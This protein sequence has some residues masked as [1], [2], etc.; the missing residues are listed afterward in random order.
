MTDRTRLEQL[1]TEELRRRAFSTAEHRLDVG[2]FWALVRHLQPTASASTEDGSAGGIGE[3][4]ADVVGI[5]RQLS[6]AGFGDNE[7]MI[8]SHFVDYLEE[9]GS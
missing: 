1:D 6:G 8:R 5:A 2:F 3:S 4:L 7:P 9:H